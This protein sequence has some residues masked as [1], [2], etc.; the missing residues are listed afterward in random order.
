MFSITDAFTTS[1]CC[2]WYIIVTMTF[3]LITCCELAKCYPTMREL[4]EVWKVLTVVNMS[5]V[6]YYFR[7][8][9]LFNLTFSKVH[10]LCE[11]ISHT[12]HE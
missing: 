5:A 6:N 8:F 7:K 3:G 4:W 10:A 11:R 2:A 9:N 12:I 1:R